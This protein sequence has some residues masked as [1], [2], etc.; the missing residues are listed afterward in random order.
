MTWAEFMNIF[1][2]VV[3]AVQASVP[4]LLFVAGLIFGRI[5]KG[6]KEVPDWDDVGQCRCSPVLAHSFQHCLCAT[7]SF[8]DRTVGKLI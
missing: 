3:T 2:T 7:L 1:N 5:M 8:G 4:L 6:I